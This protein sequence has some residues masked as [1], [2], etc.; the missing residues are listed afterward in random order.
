MTAD[1][2]TSG[3]PMM[4]RR[5]AISGGG[6]WL[7]IAWAVI[8][9]IVVVVVSWLAINA[10]KTS[11]EW[12]VRVPQVVIQLLSADRPAPTPSA[13]PVAEVPPPVAVEPPPPPAPAP[14]LRRALVPAP[15]PAMVE[16]G[17]HGPLPKLGPLGQRP[18]QVYAHPFDV[19]T[20]RPLVAVLLTGLGLEAGE[21]GTALDRLPPEVSLAF[22][23]YTP[24]L[25]EWVANVRERGHEVL[26][27]L[28]LE[29]IDFPRV[30]PGPFTLLASLPAAENQDR[31]SWVL[32]RAP[33]IV[34]VVAEDGGRF[35]T[36]A[37]A[38]LPVIETL[39][40]RGLMVVDPR[41]VSGSLTGRIARDIGVARALGTAV[42]INEQ[43]PRTVDQRLFEAE[44]IA[45]GGGAALVVAT[46][47]PAV[48][49]RLQRWTSLLPGRGVVLAPV[50]AIANRQPEP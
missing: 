33:G 4:Q 23:P 46:P 41:T 48:L 5:S 11:R 25:P 19:P 32:S 31:L 44:A 40:R 36:S 14:V 37:R 8:A 12:P 38:V 20:D 29:P 6:R 28:A 13:P 50:T 3:E 39:H 17:P 30:D 21:V 9:A 18:L 45:R 1:S 15:I 43:N 10:D 16:A 42:M 49:D 24:R 22:S 26:L 35:A 27:S 47:T 7:M 2:L 34:G